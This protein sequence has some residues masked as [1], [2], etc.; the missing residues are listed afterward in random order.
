MSQNFNTLLGSSIIKND[1]ETIN[2]NFDAVRSCHSGTAAPTDNLVAGM[3][4]FDTSTSKLYQ[5][6]P[7]LTTWVQ[8]ADLSS[9]I[10]IVPKASNADTAT[11]AI[12]DENG[13]AI[14]GYVANI[15]QDSSDESVFNVYDGNGSL[16][17]TI[18]IPKVEIDVMTGASASVDG[19]AGLVPA[20]SAGEQNKA[21]CGDGTYKELT[22]IVD[23]IPVANGGTGATTAANARINLGVFNSSGHLTLPN[24]SEFWIA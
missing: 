5:L 7:D 15:E 19:V 2:E 22:E 1:R 20:P 4:W 21:L 17:T 18:V 16:V 11:N 14:S 6:K 24:G 12:N 13:N 23:V 9:S 10:A 3:F 8:L